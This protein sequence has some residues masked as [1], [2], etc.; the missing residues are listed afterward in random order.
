MKYQLVTILLLSSLFISLE[1]KAD[2]VFVII[3]KKQEQKRQRGFDMVSWLATKKQMAL[4]DQWLAM[5]TSANLFEFFIGGGKTEYDLTHLLAT[6][7]QK[8]NFGR[9]GAYYTILGAE[10]EFESSDEKFEMTTAQIA[11]RLFGTSN[12][13]TNLTAHFGGRQ[14]ELFRENR[15]HQNLFYGGRINLYLLSFLGAEGVY[16]NYL[17]ETNNDNI[18]S[19]GELIEY[20]A[21][22]DL[23]FLRISWSLFREKTHYKLP[24]SNYMDLHK[25]TH[26]GATIFM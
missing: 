25:G 8:G 5:N 18:K 2:D 6:T 11:L 23:L 12:Q 17:P 1:T 7:P 19:H 26:L 15:R 16:R 3:M 21:F 14:K 22:I 10:G 4:M 9:L 13:G 24:N 20:G